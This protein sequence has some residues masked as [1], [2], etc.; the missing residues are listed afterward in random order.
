MSD[1]AKHYAA[2]RIALLLTMASG[3]T[4]DEISQMTLKK[5]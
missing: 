3:L 4:N 5:R 2:V 1:E